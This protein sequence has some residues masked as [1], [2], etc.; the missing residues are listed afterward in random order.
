MFLKHD[1]STARN[2]HLSV[3]WKNKYSLR[4]GL[5]LSKVGVVSLLSSG[6]ITFHN[7][8]H[9]FFFGGGGGGSLVSRA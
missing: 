5:V 6:Y 2:F 4:L 1:M 9:D 8:F 3:D 7:F